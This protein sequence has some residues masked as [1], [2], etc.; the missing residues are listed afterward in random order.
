M[1]GLI[2][3][4]KSAFSKEKKSQKQIRAIEEKHQKEMEALQEACMKE[5]AEQQKTWSGIRQ[6]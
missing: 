6:I 5:Q 4:V 1:I 3:A 2:A